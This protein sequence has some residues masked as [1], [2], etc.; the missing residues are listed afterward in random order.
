MKALIIILMFVSTTFLY[1]R[2]VVMGVYDMYPACF[3]DDNGNIKGIYIDIFN[4]IARLNGWHIRY[5]YG[6]FNEIY[7]KLRNGDI[8]IVAGL[9]RSYE[10]EAFLSF[11]GRSILQSFPTFFYNKKYNIN[12][13]KDLNGLKVGLIKSDINSEKFI[14]MCED[15][16]VQPKFVYYDEYKDVISQIHKDSI[17][18]AVLK[19]FFDLDYEEDEV[20]RKSSIK[21]PSATAHI[22]TKRDENI[23]LLQV[24]DKQLTEWKDDKNSIFFKI[25]DNWLFKNN[26]GYLN[27]NNYLIVA[28]FTLIVV[29]ALFLF[30][31]IRK[32][33]Q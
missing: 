1:S 27:Y 13:I 21:L 19:C 14:Q 20:L 17:V 26:I 33:K 30:K 31:K 11:S 10:R 3:K 23:D 24:V 29:Y 28:I 12:T 15:N 18:G 32:S 9:V 8:D 4:E 22:C 6:P 7:F 25:L 16:N 5:E 2:D